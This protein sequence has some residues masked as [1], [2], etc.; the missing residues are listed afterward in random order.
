[1][2]TLND[3]TR[4]ALRTAY[5]YIVALVG[6]VPTL[7]LLVPTGSPLAAKLAIVLGY[8]AIATKV[9]NS[10]EDKGLIP[11][12]LK[13][14]ASEGANPVPDDLP[15]RDPDVPANPVEDAL[16]VSD[17]DTPVHGEEDDLGPDNGEEDTPAEGVQ[18][19]PLV[20]NIAAPEDEDAF[21]EPPVDK[22][23]KPVNEMDRAVD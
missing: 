9:L 2:L 7:V 16:Q 23:G 12:W 18:T 1:M 14:P 19:S 4:R 21:E 20:E 6:I 11:A 5:Q 10:L 13:A 8:V 22:D 15:V 17:D 3:S